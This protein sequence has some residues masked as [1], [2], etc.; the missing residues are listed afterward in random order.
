MTNPNSVGLPSRSAKQFR[1]SGDVTKGF[2]QSALQEL[3]K[4]YLVR[5]PSHFHGA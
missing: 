2:F 3:F 5:P 1:D 4:K